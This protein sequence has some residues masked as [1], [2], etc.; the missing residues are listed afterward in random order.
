MTAVFTETVYTNAAVTPAQVTKPVNHCEEL[1]RLS[2]SA[3]IQLG[4]LQAWKDTISSLPLVIADGLAVTVALFTMHTLGNAFS[5]TPVDPDLNFAIGALLL[6]LFFQLLHGLYP[7]CGMPYS[8]EFCRVLQTC[9]VSTVSLAFALYG[10]QPADSWSWLS[11][12]AFPLILA[13]L[14][15]GIRPVTRRLLAGCDWW[16]Q[17]VA[18][19][20]N[21]SMALDL[22]NRINSSRQEGLRAI[23]VV[24]DPQ[25]HWGTNCD[26]RNPA[27]IGPVTDLEA[28]L[29]STRTCRLLIAECDHPGW[30]DYHCFHGVPH[31]SMPTNL[32]HQPIQ[33]SQL[34]ERNGL[35]Q[36]SCRTALTRPFSLACKRIMDLVLVL[37]TVPVWVPLMLTI[38]CLIKLSDPGPVLYSQ[39]RVGRYRR[40]FKALKFRSMVLNADA[41]LQNCLATHSEFRAEWDATHKLK[42]DPRVTSIGRFLRRTSL[43]E[44][45]QLLNV[46]MGDMSLVGPRPIIDLNDYDSE[47]ISEHPEVFVMYQMV[48]PGITGL[49]QISGRNLLPYKQRV[50]LDRYYLHNWNLGLDLFI[51]WRTLKT[52]LLREGAC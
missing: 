40:P 13:A 14:L 1:P 20:G 42:K 31:V 29:I 17:P 50:H 43:D 27:Y 52:A 37:L 30:W 32:S 28:I 23:G 46:L 15:G 35:I 8:I 5:Q 12:L 21:N 47:Y 24:F 2:L 49:W 6:T 34:T 51:I 33:N 3:A 9:L 7:A 38:A 44:L 22:V 36:I 39:V 18:I 48:R 45:P 19:L 25:R 10:R 26:M 16:A 11:V 4:K 41:Y